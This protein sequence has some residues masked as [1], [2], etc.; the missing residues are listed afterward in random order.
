MLATPF[1]PA[2][3]TALTIKAYKLPATG[4]YHAELCSD[5]GPLPN[6]RVL[7]QTLLMRRKYVEQSPVQ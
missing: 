6:E 2:H 4:H 7:V 5:N 3:W 1:S